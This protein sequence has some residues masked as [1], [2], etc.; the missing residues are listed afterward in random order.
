MCRYDTV[1]CCTDTRVVS[2][3]RRGVS[4]KG[5]VKIVKGRLCRA[6]VTANT[7]ANHIT[8]EGIVCTVDRAKG[9]R[10]GLGGL[11]TLRGVV[12]AENLGINRG[13][14]DSRLGAGGRLKG[15]P[16]SPE[17]VTLGRGESFDACKLITEVDR[18]NGARMGD[19]GLKPTCGECD[20]GELRGD[21]AR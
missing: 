7:I 16:S 13:S 9:M 8:V 1:R 5:H 4:Q 19:G 18:A 20:G 12:V 2:V 6:D 11:S 17:G 15:P 21:G 14:D 3:R 10:I